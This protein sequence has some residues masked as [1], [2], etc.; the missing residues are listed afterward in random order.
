[1]P[2]LNRDILSELLATQ[3]ENYQRSYT[4]EIMKMTDIVDPNHTIKTEEMGNDWKN[5]L[6]TLW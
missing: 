2:V 5:R 4:A 1:L 6:S 3:A